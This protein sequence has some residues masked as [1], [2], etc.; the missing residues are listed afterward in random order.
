MATAIEDSDGALASS[1]LGDARSGRKPGSGPSIAQNRSGAPD[2]GQGSACA[3]RAIKRAFEL[4][5]W[6]T[7]ETKQ[8]KS[9]I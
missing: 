2:H 5:S 8:A 4:P 7:R 9:C 3:S 6:P 1:A